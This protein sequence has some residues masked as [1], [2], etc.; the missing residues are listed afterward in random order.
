[1]Y[2]CKKFAGFISIDCGVTVDYIDTNTGIW[3]QPDT[4]FVET[5]KN[6]VL[7]PNQNIDNPYSID[8][9]Y[10][11]TQLHTLRS[12]PEGNRSCYTLNPKQGK[13]NNYLIRAFFAY[14]NYDYINKA[15][16]F[17]LYI[18]VYY[19]DTIHVIGSYYYSEINYTPSTDTIYVCLVNTG[20]GIP[21]ISS[22]ELRPLNNSIYQTVSTTMPQ[23]LQGRYAVGILS[24]YSHIR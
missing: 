21:F 11:G 8:N 19:W 1:M 22:L 24:D 3:Y 4:G 20:Q 23:Y 14:G 18:G 5:G 13:N 10:I 12:F 15:P 9:P 7:S 17:D 2:A 16:S 6:H